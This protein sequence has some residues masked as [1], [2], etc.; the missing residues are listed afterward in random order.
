MFERQAYAVQQGQ[1]VVA[2]LPSQPSK[3]WSGMVNYVYPE[4]DSQTRTLPVRVRLMNKDQALK[5][6]MLMTMQILDRSSA[7]VL[8]VPRSAVIK[9]GKHARV[10]K[11]LGDGRFKSVVVMLGREGEL[12]TQHDGDSRIDAHIEILS[13]LNTGD[14]VVTS[15]QF[16]IDSESNIEAELQRMEE[17]SLEG[18]S[19][20]GESVSKDSVRTTGLVNKRMD[21]MGMV[22]I[23]HEPI[24]E[25][26]WG[27]MTMDFSVDSSIALSEFQE[28]E[29][30]SFE[31]TK[32]GDWE[33]VITALIDENDH[34]MDH[35]MNH[36]MH[37][38]MDHAMDHEMDHEMHHDMEH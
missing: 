7:E 4:L 29:T 33:F 18:D 20:S 14:V 3:D 32:Q 17:A 10:V 9:A 37:H 27:T 22:N 19:K 16:L 15:A 31:L 8:S 35:E 5:P 30:L 11:S 26:D 21:V 1:D 24:P 25:W 28:G 36:E 34:H 2:Q 6:N 23:T 13:G 38:D 12:H